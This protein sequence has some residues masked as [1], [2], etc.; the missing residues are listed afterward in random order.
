MDPSQKILS[1]HGDDDLTNTSHPLE[2]SDC[3]SFL[4]CEM[5]ACEYGDAVSLSVQ[6]TKKSV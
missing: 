4:H 5:L 6:Q 3:L 2:Q 1:R